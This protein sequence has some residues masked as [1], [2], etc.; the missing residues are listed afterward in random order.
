MCC[1]NILLRYALQTFSHSI[2]HPVSICQISTG[3]FWWAVDRR[4][5]RIYRILSKPGTAQP[6]LVNCHGV[7]WIL[8][9]QFIDHICHYLHLFTLLHCLMCLSS[10]FKCYIY[11][12]TMCDDAQSYLDQELWP[13]FL[14][15]L[16]S[17]LLNLEQTS[18]NGTTLMNQHIS[19]KLWHHSYHTLLDHLKHRRSIVFYYGLQYCRYFIF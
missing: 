6:A 5:D 18:S 13:F 4:N 16:K 1:S 17:H 9:S 11:I 14:A 15:L 2:L 12:G 19:F 7:G 10:S 8:Q 3:R